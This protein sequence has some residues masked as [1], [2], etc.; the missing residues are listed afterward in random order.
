MLAYE[1]A[2]RLSAAGSPD[3]LCMIDSGYPQGDFDGDVAE[4]MAADDPTETPPSSITANLTAH[5]RYRPGRYAGEVRLALSR[6]RTR[7]VGRPGST[8]CSGRRRSTPT[9]TS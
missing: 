8:A 5:H 1:L 9:T 7:P 3:A 4:V 2:R 6:R